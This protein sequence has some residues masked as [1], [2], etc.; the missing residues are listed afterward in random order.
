MDIS[1]YHW[2]ARMARGIHRLPKVSPGPAM[3]DPSMPCGLANPKT[4][5]QPFLGWPAYR[6]GGLWP[7]TPLDTPHRMGLI[8]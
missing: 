5:I 8:I 7:S 3:P 6:A 4:S 1:G 2:K